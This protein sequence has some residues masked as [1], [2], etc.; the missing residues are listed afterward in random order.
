MLVATLWAFLAFV[1][2]R[3][4]AT[5]TTDVE[6]DPFAHRDPYLNLTSD[7]LHAHWSGN[8]DLYHEDDLGH[9]LRGRA[10][11]LA[12]RLAMLDALHETTYVDVRL[13]GFAGDGEH[14]IHLDEDKV[15]RLLDATL[16][17]EPQFVV[18]P[19]AS[20][21]SHELPVRRRFLFRVTSAAPALAPSIAAAIESHIASGGSPDA[22]PLGLVDALVR[23]D[24]MHQR[25]SHVTLYLLS[26]RAPRREPTAFEMLQASGGASFGAAADANSSS[27][28]S[29]WWQKVRYMYLDGG[30]GNATAVEGG[31][32]GGGG[33]VCP[34][35]RWV[36][37]E[38]YMWVDLSAGPISYGP[39]TA[40]DDVVTDHSLPSILQLSRRF[41]ERAEL[42][43]HLAVELAALTLNTA[44]MLL[45]PPVSRL[46]PPPPSV[47]TTTPSALTT[48][49]SVLTTTP[50]ALTI[51]A[52]R[53]SDRA[54]AAVG[55]SATARSA[56]NEAELADDRAWEAELENLKTELRPLA[57]HGQ[58]LTIETVDTSLEDCHLCAAALSTAIKAGANFV[59]TPLAGTGSTGAVSGQ[60][61]GHVRA[62]DVI[63]SRL[64]ASSIRAGL[65]VARDLKEAMPQGRTGALTQLPIRAARPNER[66]LPVVVYSLSTAEPVL[67]DGLHVALP[68]SELVLAVQTRPPAGAGTAS[69]SAP[70]LPPPPPPSLLL[71]EQCQGMAISLH[72][73]SLARPL[74][75]AL[76]QSG[77]GIVP[78][79]TTWSAAHNATVTRLLWSSAHTPHGPYS[80]RATLSFA[81]RDAAVRAPL[82]ARI[83]E[84]LAE[85]RQLA[86]HFSEFGKTIDEVLR[87]AEH[88]TFLRRLNLLAY[89]LQRVRSF[90]SLQNF[91]H[92]QYYVLSTRHDLRAMRT[93][94]EQAGAMLK[95]GLVCDV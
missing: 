1:D 33:G 18:H 60:V 87:P 21:A 67:L 28:A 58:T 32:G 3:P 45:A 52:L 70:A 93:V 42:S 68:F 20:S 83:T 50:A 71:D 89:K 48:T 19:P 4:R 39:A 22:V 82:Y 66:L 5:L 26:P 86:A 17:E 14:E 80:A 53:I 29:K 24:Y 64:L 95:A 57:A 85:V 25:G 51:V 73:D 55:S 44:R 34:V 61:L 63:D 75:S 11:T 81:Q 56:L 94:L 88:L 74:L 23:D 8:E 6:S 16:H 90:L 54:D 38:R 2:A 43:K 35:A 31:G 77:W 91:R 10:H 69:S 46:Q 65:T 79:G 78:T 59:S 37:R 72:A 49:P 76:L 92:A 84:A 15:Q 9:A 36:G 62:H 12:E 47:L 30:S 41:S 13:A 27:I 40:A 7:E